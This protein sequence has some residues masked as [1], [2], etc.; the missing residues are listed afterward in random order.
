MNNVIL[1]SLAVENYAS[2]ADRIMFTTEID[3]SKKEYLE[4]TFEIADKRF[5]KVSILYGANGSGKTFFCKILREIKRLL[6]WSPLMA[7]NNSQLL[8]LPQFKGMDAPVKP[9]VFD[10]AYQNKPT[11]FEIEL[12]IDKTT[13]HYEFNILGKKIESELLT[14]KYR[15]TEKL[16][17]RT[18]S[19]FKDIVLR[20]GLKDFEN[21]KQAVKEEALCLPIAALLNNE[22]ASKIVD[23]IQGIQVVSMT[24]ARLKPTKSKESV[25]D[26]RLKKYLYFKQK[27]DPS[28]R[29]IK[30]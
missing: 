12:V 22:L 18:S 1:R 6:D 13:Y 29:D 15:R 3:A 8:S 30:V 26:E 9:F 20:S 27:A 16:I 25:S 17:E 4:N 5:N 21:K 14:K 11:K 7:M 28:R 24:A 19:S 2:F 10:I 23:A